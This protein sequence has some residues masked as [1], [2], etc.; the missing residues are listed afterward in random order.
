[1][2]ASAHRRPAD[3]DTVL[4]VAQGPDGVWSVNEQGLNKAAMT[5]FP[6]RWAALRHAVKAAHDKP[7]CRVRVLQPDGAEA[8]SRIYREPSQAAQY[9]PR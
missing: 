4:S 7:E 8:C 1:M 6:S 9:R 3:C 5:Y 2:A